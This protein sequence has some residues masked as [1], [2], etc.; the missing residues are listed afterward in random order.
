VKKGAIDKIQQFLNTGDKNVMF[1][2]KEYMQY[3]Q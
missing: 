3:Y 1:S 2:A